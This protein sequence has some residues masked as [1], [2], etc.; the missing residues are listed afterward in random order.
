MSTNYDGLTRNTW[1]GT[2]SSTG[3]HPI[4]LDT[5][6]R[7]TL[8]SIS[9]D[10]GDRLTNITGQRLT[11]GM[12]VYLKNG[13]TVG[14]VTR[15]PDSYYKYSLLNG[16]SRNTTTGSMPNSEDNWTLFTVNST[17]NKLEDI[18]NVDAA[19]PITDGS[20]L[21]Y[22]VA[23]QKWVARTALT[24]ITLDAGNYT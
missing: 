19:A 4:V 24:G 16:Q 17:V 3:D 13:Y 22:D 8:Q 9:G 14:S 1:T 15:D 23:T 6:V 18:G 21:Q 12:L 5:E 10:A 2:W 7:G 11:E 20:V